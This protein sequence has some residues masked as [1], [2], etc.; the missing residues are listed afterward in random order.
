MAN[1]AELLH[2]F[3]TTWRGNSDPEPRAH[4]IAISHLDAIEELLDEMDDLKMRTDIYRRYFDQWMALTL[5]TPHGWQPQTNL[6]HIDDRALENLDLLADRFN[7]IVAKIQPDGLEQIRAYAD[8]VRELLEEDTSVQ[9]AGLRRHLL[10]VLAHL[11]WCVDNFSAVGEFDLQEAIE[12]LVAAM[13]RVT[14]NSTNKQRWR[15]KLNV[16]A[17][18]FVA[19]AAANIAAAPVQLAITAALT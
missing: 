13:I 17:W 19:G 9:D 6:K 7:D 11:N 1:P 4:R 15:D 12:R 2:T 3:L 5:H 14:A 16:V 18:P 8:E 10:Q